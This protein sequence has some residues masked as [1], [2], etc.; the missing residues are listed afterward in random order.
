MPARNTIREFVENGYYH[1]YNRGV[2]KRIIFEDE[3]DYTV[4]LHFIKVLLSPLPEKQLHPLAELTGFDP[5]R[6]RPLLTTLHGKVDLVAYCLMPNHF[7]LLLKQ[8]PLNGMS[9]FM[10]RLATCYV[11]YFNRKYE[12]SGYLFQGRYKAVLVTED[13]YLLHLSRYIHLNPYELTG[14][15]LVKL[16]KLSTYPYSSYACYL[17]RKNAEWLNPTP[18]LSFFKSRLRTKST[19]YT[20]Y[21]SFVEDFKEDPRELVGTLAID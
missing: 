7:H 14:S 1:V 16:V 21:Q 12:R 19:K 17:G 18:I 5:I 20:S 13:S 6:F 10:R 11:M 15:D 9:E 4:F 3:Q 2:D 8:V